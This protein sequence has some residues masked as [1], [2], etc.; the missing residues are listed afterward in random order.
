MYKGGNVNCRVINIVVLYMRG[1]KLVVGI[2]LLSIIIGQIFKR[3]IEPLQNSKGELYLLLEAPGFNVP[4]LNL[5][6]KIIIQTHKK[7]DFV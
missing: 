3:N 4:E 7:I 6:Q 1:W 5:T 2:L